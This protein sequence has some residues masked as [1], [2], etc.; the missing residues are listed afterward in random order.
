MNLVR[1]QMSWY[2]RM[3]KLSSQTNAI[4][5]GGW[6][7]IQPQPEMLFHEPVQAAFATRF[8]IMP[9]SLILIWERGRRAVWN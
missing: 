9:Y 4:L 1:R 7:S 5:I 3:Y 8:M 6:R 2:R